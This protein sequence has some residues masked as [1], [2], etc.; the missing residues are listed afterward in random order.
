MPDLSLT[1]D[2]DYIKTDRCIFRIAV[3]FQ[4]IQSRFGD[5]PHFSG[6]DG[7]RRIAGDLSGAKLYFDKDEVGGP[8]FMDSKD[9]FLF[10]SSN[11]VNLSHSVSVI[12]DKDFHSLFFQI[13]SG[14][15]LV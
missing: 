15:T 14:K 11:Q 6:I 13:E 4:K 7:F 1:I 5:L 3:F 9:L 10:F 8:D 12:S 2:P